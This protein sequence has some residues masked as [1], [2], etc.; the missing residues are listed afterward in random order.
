M[1]KV[2]YLDLDTM[3][4][5]DGEVYYLDIKNLTESGIWSEFIALCYRKM[6]NK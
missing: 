1:Y 4:V 6:C 5:Q 3:V 2:L